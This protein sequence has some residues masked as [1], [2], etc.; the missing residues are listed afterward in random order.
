MQAYTASLAAALQAAAV[1][2][3][4]EVRARGVAEVALVLCTCLAEGSLREVAAPVAAAGWGPVCDTPLL[5][6]HLELLAHAVGIDAG[7]AAPPAAEL[8]VQA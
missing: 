8:V 7:E 4:M 1:P 2:G 3:P 5:L 6:A